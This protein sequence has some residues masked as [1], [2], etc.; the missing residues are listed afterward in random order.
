MNEIL[1]RPEVKEVAVRTGSNLVKLGIIAGAAVFANNAFK[2]ASQG[3]IEA[4]KSD[5]Y[6]IK[7]IIRNR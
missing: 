3:V 6:T 4:A 2:Q 5:Y 1:N 7:D